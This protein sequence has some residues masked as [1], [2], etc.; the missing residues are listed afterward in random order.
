MGS[1]SSRESRDAELVAEFV[2]APFFLFVGAC[3]PR[4][5]RVARHFLGLALTAREASFAPEKRRLAAALHIDLCRRAWLHQFMRVARLRWRTEAR[6]YK[7][8]NP[9]V[10]GPSEISLAFFEIS[11]RFP[12]FIGPV[13]EREA[14]NK[15][16][17]PHEGLH[18]RGFQIV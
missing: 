1:R 7:T 9:A 4:W 17:A 16:G 5:A 2:G 12:A 3:A 13:H 6:R 8:G 10:K 11:Y 15:I 14:T 18:A